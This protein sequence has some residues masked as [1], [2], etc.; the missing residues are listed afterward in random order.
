VFGVEKTDEMIIDYLKLVDRFD[1]DI[2]RE[3]VALK[4][5]DYDFENFNYD[6]YD[7][8]DNYTKEEIMSMP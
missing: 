5:N 7:F 8:K 2:Q 1:S 3:L 6:E 4:M